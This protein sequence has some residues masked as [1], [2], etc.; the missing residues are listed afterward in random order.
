MPFD[1]RHK[2][3]ALP[4]KWSYYFRGDT[5]AGGRGNIR[6]NGNIRLKKETCCNHFTKG[7]PGQSML[8]N[9][10]CCNNLL[11]SAQ[12]P[13]PPVRFKGLRQECQDLSFFLSFLW[14]DCTSAPQ[15]ALS[16]SVLSS[17]SCW[18]YTLCI[19]YCCSKGCS[20][21]SPIQSSCFSLVYWV[22]RNTGRVCIEI[23][24]QLRRLA[25]QS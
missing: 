9:M 13:S 8:S 2:T 25:L 12:S 15:T 10:V 21:L 5:E 18:F 7:K 23:Q 6:Q 16:D 3:V 1:C 17:Y 11:M 24:K 19:S 14:L 20:L 4:Q 22:E